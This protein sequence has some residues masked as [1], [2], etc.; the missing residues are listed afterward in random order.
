M[1]NEKSNAKKESSRF[2]TFF[3]N[4]EQYGLD[5][6]N[7]KEIIASMNITNVPKTPDFIKGVI[8]VRGSM[9]TVID[10]KEKFLNQEIEPQE[11]TCVIIIFTNSLFL[12]L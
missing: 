4:E 5:I 2:L 9:V 6:S 10:L 1:S 12:R 7:V 8:N 11:N 3:I